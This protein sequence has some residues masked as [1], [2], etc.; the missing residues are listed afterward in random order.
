VPVRATT[1]SARYLDAGY[2]LLK[3][4]ALTPTRKATL[5][6]SL[7]HERVD[8]LYRSVAAPQLQADR[9]QDQV[10]LTGAIGEVAANL[11]HTRFGDNLADIPSILKTLTRRDAFSA[12]A[13]LAAFFS[14]EPAGHSP[15]WPRVAYT[16]DCVHQFAPAPPING[17]FIDPSTIPDQVSRA[18][19]MTA[20]WQ[21][22][23]WRVTYRLSHSLQDN[24]QPGREAADLLNLIHGLTFGWNP[25]PVLELN[26]DLNHE[27]AENRGARQT[28]RALRFVF[29][30]N[31]KMTERATLIAHLSTL[32]A[33]G[34]AEVA[35]NNHARNTEF[36]LQWAWRFSVEQAQSRLKKVQT[37]LFMRYANRFASA[38][39]GA[40]GVNT[41]TR[42]DTFNT[43]VS[44][45]FF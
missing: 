30:A 4:F 36:D 41:M 11:S 45:V 17:G 2:D 12:G 29:G 42:L 20:E 40:F 24:R 13:P 8:P 19:T 15:L 3:D 22:Q 37:Q 25:W 33:R 23:S 26:F 7:R 18:Q 1:R 44:L 32:G 43:G 28:D 6:L 35:R 10:E 39:D 38:Q 34:F 5:T 31:W 16:Y 14:R 27:S 9:Q 21:A